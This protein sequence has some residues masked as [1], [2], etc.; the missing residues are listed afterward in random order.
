[1]KAARTPEK[2]AFLD[3]KRRCQNPKTSRYESY[4]GRGIQFRYSSFAEFLADVGER[5]G[6]GYSLD[7]INVDGHYEL[8]NCRWATNRT[9]TNNRRNNRVITYMGQSKTMSEWSGYD[10]R[11]ADAIR[12]KIRCGIPPEKAVEAVVFKKAA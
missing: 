4:G 2:Q 7:R 9:Q 12:T 3:A 8:G 5:P 6:K 11:M 1:M 10:R